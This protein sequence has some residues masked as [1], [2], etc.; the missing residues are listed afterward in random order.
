MS[1]GLTGATSP[2]SFAAGTTASFNVLIGLTGGVHV[3]P[4]C[5]GGGTGKNYNC[6]TDPVILLRTA[7]T[8]GSLNY[9]IDCGQIPGNTGGNLYQ[10]MR[11]GCAQQLLDQHR[12]TSAPTPRCPPRRTARL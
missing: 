4:K 2:Y 11:Y 8:S 3:N 7:S 9:A 6:A 5:P 10:M 1:A 12:R